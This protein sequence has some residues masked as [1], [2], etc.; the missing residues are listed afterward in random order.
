VSGRRGRHSVTSRGN[1][2]GASAPSRNTAPG[3]YLALMARV[4]NP[5]T[6]PGD[7]RGAVRR[8]I[9]RHTQNRPPPGDHL[10]VTGLPLA[11]GTGLEP[12]T[13]GFGVR[14]RGLPLVFTTCREVPFTL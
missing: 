8:Q 2:T 10:P 14:S 5:N 1:G 11:G 12:A 3:V 13:Y 7:G 9:R 6:Q 4:A